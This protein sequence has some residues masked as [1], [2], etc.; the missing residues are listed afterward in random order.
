MPVNMHNIHNVTFIIEGK[1]IASKIVKLWPKKPNSTYY[2][3]FISC[4]DCHYLTIQGGG[5]IDGRGY[6]WWLICILNDKKL[7]QGIAKR[8]SHFAIKSL[9]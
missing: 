7:L 2:Q 8:L 5:K 3:D 9:P 4:A 1:M 6:H